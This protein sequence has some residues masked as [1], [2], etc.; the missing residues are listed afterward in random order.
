MKINYLRL[1]VTDRCNLNCVYCQPLGGAG[2]IPHNEILRYEEMVEIVKCLASFGVEKVRI[3][4]GE[5][6]MRRNVSALVG[7]LNDLPEIKEINMTTNGLFLKDNLTDL[8]KA[9]LNRINISLNT[10]KPEIYEQLSKVDGFNRVWDAIKEAKKLGLEKDIKIN[11]ILFKGINDNE[12]LDFVKLVT[13]EDMNV[14]FIEYFSTHSESIDLS[15]SMVPNTVVKGIVEEKYGRLEE[16]NGLR[17]NGPSKNYCIKG[18]KGTIGFI[19][20]NTEYF[21]G[22]CNRIRLSADGRLFACLFSNNSINLK[23][24]VR[25]N[26]SIQEIEK[27][28][29]E[30]LKIKPN[31]NKKNRTRDFHMSM[32][33]G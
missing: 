16:A 17:G 22:S 23:D 12:V 14:R 20:S 9:G 2:F 25:N 33:G 1:S 27:A 19:D 10:L 6:L 11:V 31:L 7:M 28:I 3:T 30:L 24:M 18:Y 26:C 5:P 13:E 8:R 29:S 15:H 32:I 4:G 21:C